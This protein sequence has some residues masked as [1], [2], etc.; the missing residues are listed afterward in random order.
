MTYGRSKADKRAG[1]RGASPSSCAEK[2]MAL[3]AIDGRTSGM[4]TEPQVTAGDGKL[5]VEQLLQRISE[6]YEGL[7]KQLKIIAR[8]I[9]RNRDRLGI[10]GIRELAEQCE[11][12]PSA[13]VRFAK[14]FGLSGFAEMQRIFRDGLAQYL[15]QSRNYET[16][17]RKGIESGAGKLSSPEIADEFLRGSIAGMQELRERLHGPSFRKAVNL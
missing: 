16:R 17:I 8:H 2:S 10:E 14:H 6:E 15:G 1:S 5:T 13:V 11:V 4:F 7:S 3:G 9:E 12:Q